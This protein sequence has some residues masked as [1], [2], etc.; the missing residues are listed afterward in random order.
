M[1]LDFARQAVAESGIAR[2]LLAYFRAHPDAADTERGIAAFWLNL[3]VSQ[4]RRE[5]EKLLLIGVVGRMG[6]DRG[7]TEPVYRL[8]ADPAARELLDAVA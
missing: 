1:N 4:V 7:V 5:L 8:A 3:P 6:R 2:Q